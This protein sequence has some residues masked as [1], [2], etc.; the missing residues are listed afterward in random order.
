M[1]DRLDPSELYVDTS[2]VLSAITPGTPDH[3]LCRDF[4]TTFA[5]YGGR[6][7]FSQ[8]MRLELSQASARLAQ[9][10]NRLTRDVREQYG[11]TQWRQSADVRRA[12][13]AALSQD[14]ALKT[15]LDSLGSSAMC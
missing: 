5:A 13:Y 3:E 1:A 2:F 12:W 14:F 15:L 4:S 8:I 9:N 11:L 10:R 6:I 7:Y